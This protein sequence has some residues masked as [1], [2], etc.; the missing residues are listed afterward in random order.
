MRKLEQ[1]TEPRYFLKRIL[2]HGNV[3]ILQ[4]RV[5]ERHDLC[6]LAGERTFAKLGRRHLAHKQ[7]DLV[8]QKHWVRRTTYSGSGEDPG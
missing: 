2:L 1:L 7:I 4:R 5:N 3:L 6:L 8:Q